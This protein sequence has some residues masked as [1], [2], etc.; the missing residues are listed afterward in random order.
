MTKSVGEEVFAQTFQFATFVPTEDHEELRDFLY[1]YAHNF[2]EA[3]EYLQIL[4]QVDEIETDS[5]S[6]LL[7]RIQGMALQCFPLA[8]RR[9]TDNISKR[10][11][12][13]LVTRVVRDEMKADELNK[14]KAINDHYK[15]YLNKGVAHQDELSIKEILKSFPDTDVIEA[16]MKHV[17]DLYNKLVKEI[18]T[19]YIGIGRLP[20]NYEPELKKLIV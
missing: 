19:K 2:D 3:K 9:L 20:V 15:V 7:F 16:D 4:K 11:L 18:C 6:E 10:S 8:M 1:K 5:K 13:K 17:E 12:Q 14:I